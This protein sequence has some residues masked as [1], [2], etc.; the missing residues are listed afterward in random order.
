MV[1]G[2]V[3]LGSDFGLRWFT[4]LIIIIVMTA[5]ALAIVARHNRRVTTSQRTPRRPENYRTDVPQR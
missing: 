4:P 5:P 3:Y 1:A 2:S